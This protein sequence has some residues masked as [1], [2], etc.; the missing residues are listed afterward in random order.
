MIRTAVV[1]GVLA[2][3]AAWAWISVSPSL[4]GMR[5]ES[6]RRR[7]KT[8]STPGRSAVSIGGVAVGLVAVLVGSAQVVV[9]LV[10]V[11][12][13]AFA[14][15]QRRQNQRL[16]FEQRLAA[17]V[18]EVVGSLGADVAAGA[19]PLESLSAAATECA[20]SSAGSGRTTLGQCL[21]AAV[22][23][24]RLGGDVCGELRRLAERPGA[25]GL[26]DL[27]IAW[28]VAERCGARVAVVLEGV[29]EGLTE[30]QAARSAVDASL[31]GARASARLLAALP[32]FGL[33]M[34]AAL[35]A[36]PFA[37]LVG[38]PVGRGCLFAGLG[39]EATGV[40]W[41]ERLAAAARRRAS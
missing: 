12:V 33:G 5:P 18:A 29:I 30:K 38:H 36:H 17:A 40:W 15:R 24:G 8:L 28:E 2:G 10:L 3:T 19:V 7:P 37:F 23:A 1:A 39:L 31:A 4:P 14:L 22:S 32:V 35:G 21:D 9:T 16:A 6:K 27:A 26:R 11:S 13:G 20:S 41:T 34:G 25:E